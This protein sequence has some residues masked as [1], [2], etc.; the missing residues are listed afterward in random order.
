V[1]EIMQKTKSTHGLLVRYSTMTGSRTCS[2]NGHVSSC[3]YYPNVGCYGPYG[4]AFFF[5]QLVD[6]RR[7]F[8]G[9]CY[10]ISSTVSL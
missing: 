8:K 7:S 9:L 1:V 10:I 2:A 5:L 3:C 4:T 6:D